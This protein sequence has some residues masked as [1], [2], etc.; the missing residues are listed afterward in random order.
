MG[1]KKYKPTSPGRRNMSVNTFDEVTKKEPEK[2]LL[3]PLKS[4]AGRNNYGRITVRHQGGGVKRKYRI[5]DF[6]RNKD[7]VPGKV[8]GIEYDPN[9]SSN[10]ALIHYA[11]GEKRYIIAPL[12]LKVGDTIVS[13]PE[14]EITIGNCLPLKNIPVGT[15]VHNIE[16]KAGK[17]GQMVRSAGASAQLMA[18]EGN[19]ATLRLPSGEMR[20]VRLEC[21]ATVGTVGNLD[22]QNV[23]IGKAGRKRHMGIRPT[24]RGSVMNPNDHPHGG[25]EGRAPV[26][27][28]GPVTPWGKPALG[29]K[30]RKKNKP[31]DKY[32]VRRRNVK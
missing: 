30:T 18:K 16:L 20:Q 24:V 25:G 21:R 11:D 19:Y 31:S 7:G 32:I 28:S 22:H 8:A 4:K 1:I 29:Y 23:R 9:R 10:I 5:I 2:S 12:K 3:T 26:G 6:K 17:G 27:R 14:A 13:G 15:L